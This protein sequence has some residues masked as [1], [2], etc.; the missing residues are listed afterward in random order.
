[1]SAPIRLSFAGRGNVVLLTPQTVRQAMFRFLEVNHLMARQMHAFNLPGPRSPRCI[2]SQ[3]DR[4]FRRN[5]IASDD[6]QAT[7]LTDREIHSIQRQMNRMLL[8]QDMVLVGGE[9]QLHHGQMS[10]GRSV[11]GRRKV[12]YLTRF[13]MLFLLTPLTKERLLREGSRDLVVEG[14]SQRY[15][16]LRYQ[17]MTT[18]PSGGSVRLQFRHRLDLARQGSVA[19]AEFTPRRLFDI[20]HVAACDGFCLAELSPLLRGTL[21]RGGGQTQIAKP[22]SSAAMSAFQATLDDLFR[23]PHEWRR[24]FTAKQDPRRATNRDAV[25]FFPRTTPTPPY[26][27]RALEAQ[28]AMRAR[29]S[30]RKGRRPTYQG[31]LPK[32]YWSLT[33]QIRKLGGCVVSLVSR[34]DWP[35]TAVRFCGRITDAELGQF[36]GLKGLSQLQSLDLSGT[37]ITDAGLQHLKAFRNLQHLDLSRTAITGAGLVGYLRGLDDLQGLALSATRITDTGLQ[38][39]NGLPHLQSLNLAYTAITDVGLPHLKRLTQL[40]FLDLSR[41]AVTDIGL[42]Y[43][44]GLIQLQELRLWRTA[45]TDAGLEDFEAFSQL[46]NLDLSETELRGAGLEYL[47]GLSRFTSLNLDK[48]AI[49]DAGLEHLTA[50]TQLQELSLCHTKITDGGIRHLTQLPQLQKLKLEGTAV[51]TARCAELRELEGV[52]TVGEG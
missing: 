13:G 51:T 31:T 11:S 40:Q 20:R 25:V 43:L 48:T 26:T 23:L 9:S 7:H 14:H 4:L 52:P 38:Y 39:L 28:R 16:V 22:A 10:H 3:L 12:L 47:K 37:A 46:Q 8:E 42:K 17:G 21:W 1:M 45:I 6:W 5:R 15:E 29:L 24:E 2:S 32:A 34:D 19:L 30:L 41:T 49:T 33:A 35:I 27:Q 44:T 36:K 18:E 50:L